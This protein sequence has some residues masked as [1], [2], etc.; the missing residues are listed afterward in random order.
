MT[1]CEAI[2][3]IIN[4]TADIFFTAVNYHEPE[5]AR[6]AAFSLAGLAVRAVTR[7]S[8]AAVRKALA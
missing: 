1:F 3:F 4:S 6:G 5:A 2:N 8:A 7:L